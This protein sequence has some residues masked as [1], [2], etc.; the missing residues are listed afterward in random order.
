MTAG[1]WPLRNLRLTTPRLTLR[2]PTEAD[3]D[4]LADLAAA[5]V[6]DPAVQPFEAAWTDAPPD[7]RA[8]GTLQY[9][10]SKWAAWQPGDWQ[11]NFAVV[12][13][14]TVVGSQAI[15]GH[16][17]AAVRELS[18]GSWL[19]LDYQGR[20]IGT[21]MRAA[22]LSLAFEGLGAQS[23][24]SEAF[25]DNATSLGV[26]RRLGYEDDGIAVSCIRGRRVSRQRLRLDRA[27]WQEHAT[28]PVRLHGLEP[29]LRLF[30]LGG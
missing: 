11:L 5:G 29:C 13:D 25:A 28:V 12:L 24:T 10:W 18:T 14:A 26:S 23:V 30:G 6:H 22:V 2:W 7:E 19:G 20:G 8:R 3:L 15:E 27:R 17:F 4:A 9:H 16:N 1:R 21:E